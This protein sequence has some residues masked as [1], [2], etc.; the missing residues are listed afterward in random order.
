MRYLITGAGQIGQQLALDLSAAGHEVTVLRRGT[1]QIAGATTISGDAGDR[2]TLREASAGSAAI[3]HCIHTTYSAKV[4]RAELP[5]REAAVMDVAAEFDIPVVFPESVYAFGLGARQLS[6]RA[7]L[8]PVSPL[9]E[10]RA[11]L[12]RARAAHR[13][14]TSSIVASDLFGPTAT[15]AGSVVLSTVVE[16]ASNGKSAW[17]LGDPDAPHA[18]TYIP[19]LCRAMIAA[20]PLAEQGGTVLLAPTT[21][22]RTLRQMAVDAAAIVGRTQ[23]ERAKITRI[24]GV[25]LAVGGLF[26][27]P[28]REMR[29][30]R[31]LW[32]APSALEA[33]RLTTEFGLQPTPWADALA[34]W[35]HKPAARAQS[36]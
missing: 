11:E 17:A 33:G 10:V 30:Q 12:L 24:P 5:Q 4:W 3:F 31:Y 6:E 2:K 20:V 29:N 35:A 27:A 14:R 22:A 26:S 16:P 9:G 15:G 19:D 8:A 7:P 13:A 36:N 28:M 23:P 1:G 21:P 25:I 18:V 32:T 34:E